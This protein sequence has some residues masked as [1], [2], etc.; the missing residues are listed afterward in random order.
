MGLEKF[1]NGIEATE[2]AFDSVS[3]VSG[4]ILEIQQNITEIKT[5]KQTLI[6][7]MDDD[8]LLKATKRTEAKTESTVTADPVKADFEKVPDAE[9]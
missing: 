5:E 4:N 7:E 6:T 2:E 9:S 8:K 1:R 3:Q